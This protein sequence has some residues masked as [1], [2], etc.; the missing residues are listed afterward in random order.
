MV[1]G[2]G[3]E[4]GAVKQT[5]N[6]EKVG[7]L[8]EKSRHWESRDLRCK[9]FFFFLL[10][11]IWL[12]LFKSQF[13]NTYIGAHNCACIVLWSP[14]PLSTLYTRRMV[15]GRPWRWCRG[16]LLLGETYLYLYDLPLH[17]DQSILHETTSDQRAIRELSKLRRG[18]A[19]TACH[20]SSIDNPPVDD[21]APVPKPQFTALD[22]GA[23]CVMYELVCTHTRSQDPVLSSTLP[24]F[25][26][27][28]TH[29]RP[30]P[31]TLDSFSRDAIEIVRRASS[32]LAHRT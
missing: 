26:N 17:T 28:N 7:K 22:N 25:P 3:E 2:A 8:K 20:R 1:E 12:C 24:P 6:Q 23:W 13:S 5:H 16:T 32:P 9:F 27:H 19:N 30:I 18:E 10:A 15:D 21:S 11:T 31:S 29:R 14:P 4:P